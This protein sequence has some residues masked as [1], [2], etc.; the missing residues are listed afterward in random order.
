[1]SLAELRIYDT[2]C[3]T[4]DCSCLP[5]HGLLGLLDKIDDLT[6]AP[7]DQSLP[8]SLYMG[9]WKE[10]GWWWHYLLDRTPSWWNNQGKD[11]I[12]FSDVISFALAA[13]LSTAVNTYPDIIG[14]AAGAFANKGW[15]EGFYYMIGSRQSVFMRVNNAVYGTAHSSSG[16]SYDFEKFGS[17]FGEVN[18]ISSNALKLKNWGAIF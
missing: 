15:K 11:H 1:M 4:G 7:L 18:L 2:L 6:N 12:K 5:N 3:S 14:Y 8:H 9:T 17:K 10:Y 13:E 16:T